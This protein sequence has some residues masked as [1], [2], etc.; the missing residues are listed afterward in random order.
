MPANGGLARA[1]IGVPTLISI[2][3]HCAVPARAA[4]SDEARPPMPEP[5]LNETTTDIDGTKPGE[6][7]VE[8]TA[9]VLRS[10]TGGAFDLE[11][12]P[13]IELLLTRRLGVKFEP[14]FERAAI[15]SLPPKSSG[16]LTGGLS[17]K[18][19]Q[20]F[21][22]DFHLQGEMEGRVPTDSST[23]VQPGESPLPL[24]FDLRSG[25]RRSAWTLRSSV[26]VS[27][28]GPSAHVPLRG[29]AALFTGFEPTMRLGFWGIEIEADGARANPAVVA[30]DL[31]PSLLPARVPFSL[32]FVLPYSV[33]ADGKAPSYGFLVRLFI[34]SER[35]RQYASGGP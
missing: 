25:Y 30:L 6:L 18:L 31:V 4:E 2:I 8:A 17:W 12:S 32:G 3:A 34:E 1:R 29:S 22:D 26:G 13:E 7:E 28:G 33:G 14:F 24:S 15:A 10:R 16:G 19:L 5:I 27:A 23:V 35:E 9:S 20:M 11:L 21:G